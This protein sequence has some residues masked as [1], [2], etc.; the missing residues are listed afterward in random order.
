MTEE[1]DAPEEGEVRENQSTGETATYAKGKWII[2]G[3][4]SSAASTFGDVVAGGLSGLGHGAAQTLG[5]VGS[6]ADLAAYGVG[7]AADLIGGKG[8]AVTDTMNTARKGIEDYRIPGIDIPVTGPGLEAW[9]DKYIPGMNYQPKTTS[10]QAAHTLGEWAPAILGGGVGAG[11]KGGLKA[12][13]KALTKGTMSAV[14]SEAAGQAAHEYAPNVE[15]YARVGGAVLG[16]RA[17]TTA[18]KLAE[19]AANPGAAASQATNVPDW[20]NALTDKMSHAAGYGLGAAAAHYIKPGSEGATLA[21]TFGLGPLLS[22][23]VNATAGKAMKSGVGAMV[24]ELRQP[25]VPA[26][27]TAA[28]AVP[29]LAQEES[30]PRTRV[31]VGVP[32]GKKEKDK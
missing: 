20:A 3:P 31:T 4:K 26:W 16:F 23:A 24:D 17:P 18:G 9:G 32:Y 28:R 2:E 29:A 1:A 22:D 27:L 15:P 13:E 8:N 12:A 30:A 6:G 5:L 11:V 14:G 25:G 21:G 7:K 19:R 10:G